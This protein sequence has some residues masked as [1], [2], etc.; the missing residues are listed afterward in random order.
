MATPRF[1]PV[2]PRERARPID[3]AG[4]PPARRTQPRA[5]EV[6]H[7]P[8]ARGFGVPCPDG[9]YALLLAR[10]VA[11]D[12]ALAAGDQREDAVWAIA[13]VAMRRAA[14]VGRAPVIYDVLF[15]SALLA[16]DDP[17]ALECAVLRARLLS[18]VAHDP[19]LRQ[20]LSDAVNSAAEV[21]V[22]STAEAIA[23]WR[24]TILADP[25]SRRT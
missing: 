14:V 19:D 16:Y 6:L 8:R 21:S 5:G 17:D 3:F 18:G 7:Q 25:R 9:G 10:E 20:W 13:T 23:T 2:G 4:I 15:A 1:V 12:L 22:R 24:C 11:G